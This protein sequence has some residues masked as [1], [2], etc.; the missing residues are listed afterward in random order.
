MIWPLSTTMMYTLGW[1]M[2]SFPLWVFVAIV[3]EWMGGTEEQA[4]TMV[5]AHFRVGAACFW[6]FLPMSC[7]EHSQ[8]DTPYNPWPEGYNPYTHEW[9]GEKQK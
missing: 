7:W 5:R 1:C 8:D 9:E 4:W 2:V 3:I 6:L